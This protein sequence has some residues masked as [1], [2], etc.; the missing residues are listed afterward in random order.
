MLREEV[1]EGKGTEVDGTLGKKTE[2][3]DTREPKAGR[4][5]ATTPE[6]GAAVSAGPYSW[7]ALISWHDREDSG[8]RHRGKQ[9]I[10]FETD[11]YL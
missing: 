7:K 2:A 11:S 6:A 9:G 10:D 3:E 5:R 4:A 1:S 8:K